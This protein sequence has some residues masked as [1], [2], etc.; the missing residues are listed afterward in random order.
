M[1]S[2]RDG[3]AVQSGPRRAGPGA[4]TRARMLTLEGLQGSAPHQHPRSP[5]QLPSPTRVGL[6]PRPASLFL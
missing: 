5:R 3:P 6:L 2:G 1:S 4:R